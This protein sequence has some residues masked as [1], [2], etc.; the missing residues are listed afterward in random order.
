M[1]E[2]NK[3]S[4]GMKRLIHALLVPYIDSKKMEKLPNYEISWIEPLVEH[5]LDGLGERYI[6][7]VILRYGLYGRKPMSYEEVGRELNTDKPLSR[8]RARQIVARTIRVLSHSVRHMNYDEQNLYGLL[9]GEDDATPVLTDYFSNVTHP[10]IIFR[11]I[12][13]LKYIQLKLSV[14]KL[15]YRARQNQPYPLDKGEGLNQLLKG[16]TD[17]NVQ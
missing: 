6:K 17:E 15:I 10:T 4:E 1:D 3:L 12:N 5:E 16:V 2:N 11:I 8:E 7:A 13:T 14:Q 9:R